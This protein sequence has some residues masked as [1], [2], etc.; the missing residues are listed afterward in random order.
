MVNA[1]SISGVSTQ[2]DLSMAHRK[3]FYDAWM[4]HQ[5]R[6]AL[7]EFDQ[8]LIQVML[9]YPQYTHCITPEEIPVEEGLN[10]YV[11]MGAH[12]ELSEQIAL[13]RPQGVRKVFQDLVIRYDDQKAEK[14][15]LDV[16]LSVLSQSYQR[17][18]VP[19]YQVYLQLLKKCC[20]L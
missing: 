14:M 20:Q 9:K 6:L 8:R 16:L 10:P 17:S 4:R 7:S 15:M 13:D 5:E 19:D 11:V 2:R 18:E 1:L 3:V 12:L